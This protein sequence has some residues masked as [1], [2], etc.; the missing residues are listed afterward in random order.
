[1][2]LKYVEYKS[3]GSHTCELHEHWDD[4]KWL[5]VAVQTMSKRLNTLNSDQ[6]PKTISA[7]NV[8][9]D[10]IIFSFR[11]NSPNYGLMADI[12]DANGL[13][14]NG[15]VNGK[16]LKFFLYENIRCNCIDFPLAV[17][18]YKSQEPDFE[19]AKSV[20]MKSK[21]EQLTEFKQLSTAASL[22]GVSENVLAKITGSI[23][24][25]PDESN[26]NMRKVNIGL[27]L[28]YRNAVRNCL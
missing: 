7:A 8:I 26:G 15:R 9:S 10:K 22:C 6:L 2:P 18:C 23:Q 5:P 16:L 24:V 14:T 11:N 20:H 3:V 28:K 4:T 27:R 13:E 19:K 1:M 25:N 12:V 17:L 21:T